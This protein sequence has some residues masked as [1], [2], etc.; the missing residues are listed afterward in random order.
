M[1][2]AITVLVVEDE[3]LIRM[4]I[5]YQLQNLGFTVLEAGNATE[6]VAMLASNE[7]IQMMFTDVDMPGAMDGLMLAALVRDRW[8]PVKI[9]VTSGHRRVA[10]HDLPEGS[11]FFPKPY[12]GRAVA[13]AMNEML[14]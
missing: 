9:I 14:A 1:P 4:D 10:L 11:R 13:A 3:L 6:A 7:D 8:P 12:S 5:S 2:Q